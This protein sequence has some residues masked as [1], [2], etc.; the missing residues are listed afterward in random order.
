MTGMGEGWVVVFLKSEEQPRSKRLTEGNAA[1][2]PFGYG[3]G[4]VAV[5]VVYVG[6]SNAG[7]GWVHGEGGRGGVLQEG[8]VLVL[9][10]FGAVET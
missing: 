6:P 1:G 2:I 10:V 8:G 7:P 3:E 5:A 4:G 9:C